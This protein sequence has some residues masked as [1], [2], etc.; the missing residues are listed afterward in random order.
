MPQWFVFFT[1]VYVVPHSAVSDHHNFQIHS[2]HLCTGVKE[3]GRDGCKGDS[4]GG[5]IMSDGGRNGPHVLVGITSAGW[6]CGKPRV[7]AIYTRVSSFS[8]WL[9]NEII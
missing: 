6:K 2:S 1:K 9:Q 4:G 8:S 5:F 3:G 7:P